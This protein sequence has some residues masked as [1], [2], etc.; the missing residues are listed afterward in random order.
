[1]S[2]ISIADLIKTRRTRK[3]TTYT[4]PVPTSLVTSLIET[5]RHAPNHHR[6][7]PARFYLLN[8]VKMVRLAKLF[9]ETIRGDKTIPALVEKAKKKEQEW[10]SATGL[11]AVT[12]YSDQE[13][14]LVQNNPQVIEENFA[15]TCCIMQN[16]LLLF[17]NSQIAAKWSTAA[18][19]Q[20]P[21][22]APTVGI[23]CPSNEKFV[24]LIFYGY[25][26]LSKSVRNLS[27]LQNHLVDFTDNQNHE[28]DQ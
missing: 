5:A 9:G 20:H 7:E 2:Q 13:S 17:E 26:E 19:W 25:S 11:L 27:P 4:S 14:I 24:G 28:I 18:V 6:T 10:K 21:E 15:T 22:F 16:L 12:S 1:M 3:P 8:R 23:K